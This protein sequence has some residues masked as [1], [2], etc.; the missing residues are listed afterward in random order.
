[1][2]FPATVRATDILGF[3]TFVAAPTIDSASGSQGTIAFTYAGTQFI[4]STYHSDQLYSTP[5][6]GGT[7][8]AFGTALPFAFDPGAV[9]V[10]ASLGNGGFANGA[11]FAASEYSG[12]IYKYAS[13]GGTP[14]LFAT[15]PGLGGVNGIR[16]I[17]FDP[18]SG[19]GGDMLVKTTW[20]TSTKSPLV[21]EPRHCWHPSV[22]TSR[23]WTLPPAP[24]DHW[25]VTCWSD[26]R[27]AAP[28]EQ[29]AQPVASRSSGRQRSFQA[30]RRSARSP[31]VSIQP[32]PWK[33]FMSPITHTISSSPPR[34]ISP[35]SRE[36]SLLPM[37]IAR[38]LLGRDLERHK[39]RFDPVRS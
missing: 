4:G 24:L 13:S 34:A 14:T 19:F 36:A 20:A 6:G 23:E 29:S 12:Q 38:I 22:R 11:V 39:F 32:T 15:I 8:T 2:V 25:P 31:R 35:A 16:Q 33:G 17:F 7:A 28:F 26:P 27:T 3:S 10:G 18:G 30:G 37:K 1:M 9:V 21:A 5:L